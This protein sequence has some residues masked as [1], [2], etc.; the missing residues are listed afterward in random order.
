MLLEKFK[1]EGFPTVLILNPQGKGIVRDGYQ[2]GGAAKYVE[3][4]KGAIAG[5][6][7]K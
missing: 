4:I 2:R 6:Q 1:V 5:D 3:F 7:K